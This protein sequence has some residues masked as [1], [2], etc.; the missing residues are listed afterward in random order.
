MADEE[1]AFTWPPTSRE[2]RVEVG[3]IWENEGEQETVGGL[4]DGSREGGRGMG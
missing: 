1:G 2:E 3:V 4:E